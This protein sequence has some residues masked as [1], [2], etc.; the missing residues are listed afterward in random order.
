MPNQKRMTQLKFY[1]FDKASMTVVENG[2]FC[3]SPSSK[4]SR[5]IMEFKNSI[6]SA[7]SICID[8]FLSKHANEKYATLIF[9]PCCVSYVCTRTPGV[10][11]WRG[12]TVIYFP[13][14]NAAK[15]Y[16]VKVSPELVPV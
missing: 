6:K 2:R 9:E 5:R 8:N 13:V 14:Q 16:V 11:K 4:L 15:C 7:L 3:Q 10:C 1:L 12:G